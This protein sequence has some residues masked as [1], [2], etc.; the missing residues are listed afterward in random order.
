MGLE[1]NCGLQRWRETTKYN[2]CTNRDSNQA[3]YSAA[4]TPGLLILD[5][6]S[7]FMTSPSFHSTLNTVTGQMMS[8]NNLQIKQQRQLGRKHNLNENIKQQST[9][10]EFK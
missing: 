2:C 4:A 5:L 1:K 6:N 8:S 10:E 3:A 7:Q 9:L